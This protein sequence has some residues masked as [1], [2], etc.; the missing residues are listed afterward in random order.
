MTNNLSHSEKVIQLQNQVATLTQ[1][2]EKAEAGCAEMKLE[3][4]QLSMEWHNDRKHGGLYYGCDF[5]LCKRTKN[6]I[7][8]SGA[9]LLADLA[10]LRQQATNRAWKKLPDEEG[11]W[12]YWNGEEESLPFIYSVEVSHD[13][14]VRYFIDVGTGTW[15]D[16]MGGYWLKD[17]AP[18]PP[19]AVERADAEA[20][21]LKRFEGTMKAD[22]E[23]VVEDTKIEG[24]KHEPTV[25]N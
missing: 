21:W 14:K 24:E 7:R 4:E 6:L 2:A 25:D 16:E 12:W 17:E 20:A 15:C 13:G 3:L 11:K 8:N 18:A 19:T 9:T 22:T 1:R 23:R 5:E 10:A